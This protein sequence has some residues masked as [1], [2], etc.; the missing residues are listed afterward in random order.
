MLLPMLA[1]VVPVELGVARY[2]PGLSAASLPIF[3]HAAMI[4]G[5]VV[6]MIYRFE[7][8]THGTHGRCA[9]AEER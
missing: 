6:L 8:Y 7:R 3:S 5:M 4:A 1:L 9:R 2:M